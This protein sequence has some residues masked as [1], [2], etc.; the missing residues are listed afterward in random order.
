[1]QCLEILINPSIKYLKRIRYMI[2]I[3]LMIY[4]RYIQTQ[5]ILIAATTEAT[6]KIIIGC[7]NIHRLS[8]GKTIWILL[9]KKL[10]K[11]LFLIFIK[12]YSFKNHLCLYFTN[13]LNNFSFYKIYLKFYNI[14]RCLKILKV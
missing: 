1:M 4:I 8:Q 12:F 2:L 5:N 6:L 10:C 7:Q 13:L 11:A 14:Y 3:N 9:I